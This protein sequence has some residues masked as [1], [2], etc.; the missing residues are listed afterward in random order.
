MPTDD[1][2]G[3]AGHRRRF[4]HAA[5]REHVRRCREVAVAA[6]APSG[7]WA[8]P[9]VLTLPLAELGPGRGLFGSE[10]VV[11]LAVP[12][13]FLRPREQGEASSASNFSVAGLSRNDMLPMLRCLGVGRTMRLL[14]ALMSERRVITTSGSVAKLSAVTYGAVAMMGQGLLPPPPVFVPG[15]SSEE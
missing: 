10:D 11:K 14:S 4:L 3:G 7:H 6:E 9:R 8:K 5:F 13:S 12:S 1:P 15:R 2:S